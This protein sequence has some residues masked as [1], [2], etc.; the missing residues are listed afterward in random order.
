VPGSIA[1]NRLD[2]QFFMRANGRVVA[3]SIPKWR[4]GTATRRGAQD[5]APLVTKADGPAWDPSLAPS[6][7][8]NG[9]VPVD[10]PPPNSHFGIPGVQITG[11][12][13]D[14]NL[15][16]NAVVA[17]RFYVAAD[18]IVLERIAFRLKMQQATAPIRVAIC[19]DDDVVLTETNIPVPTDNAVNT[20]N[21][22]LPLPRGFYKLA[23]WTSSAA[24]FATIDG[25]QTGQGW[26]LDVNGDPRFVTRELGGA[27][28]SA[29]ID[30]T[31][32]A[33]VEQSQ[34]IPG[35]NRLLTMRWSLPV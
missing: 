22:A 8:I 31:A 9:R 34:A 28:S 14:L 7:T 35:V 15:I 2:E 23:L 13:A 5:G 11:A 32:A 33:L 20:T 19:T 30:L 1:I 27:P 6:S 4:D 24:S 12:G 26:N 10:L 17:E 21:Y 16:Q 3:I 18:R 29:G 25:F